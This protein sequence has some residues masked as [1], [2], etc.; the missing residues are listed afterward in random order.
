MST[1]DK[2]SLF[3]ANNETEDVLSLNRSGFSNIS[4]FENSTS[5]NETAE[6][7]SQSIRYIFA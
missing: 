3:A 5:G 1:L 2:I 6:V 4:N 7:N